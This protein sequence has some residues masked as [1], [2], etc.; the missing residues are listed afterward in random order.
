MEEENKKQQ[1][2]NFSD[3]AEQNLRIE[4]EL[5]KLKMQAERGALFG[6]EGK[7]P[8]EIENEFLQNVQ[9]FEEEWNE[10]KT[11]KVYDLIGRPEFKPAVL[12]SADAIETELKRLLELMARKNVFLDVLGNYEPIVIYRFLTEELF[13]H[14]TD[15]IRIAG[16]NQN[17][18]YEEFHPNHEMD[19]EKNTRDFLRHWFETGFDEYSM[20]L[21]PRLITV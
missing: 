14:E 2:E 7:I 9:R 19:I 21:A 18:I 6:G 20:E 8:P 4:N 10:R 1:E 3:D 5:L 12:L 16:W 13:E 15:D 17:F 11:I